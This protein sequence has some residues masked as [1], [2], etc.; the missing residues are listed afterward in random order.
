MKNK[1]VIITGASS[2]IG[3][4]TALAFHEKGAYLS[5]AARSISKLN[6]LAQAI[7][8]DGGKAIAIQTDVTSEKD[9]QE[10]VQKTVDTFGRVDILVNN[11][12]I[13]MR[14]LFDDV[15]IHVMKTLMEV[16]FWG[17]VYCTKFA[18]PYIQRSKGV[19]VGVSSIAGFHGLPGRCGYSA[20]KFALHGFLETVRIEN[21]H[22]G[23]HVLVFA[24]G[25][26]CTKIRES[27]LLANGKPQGKS[28]RNEMKMMSAEQ[29]AKELLRAIARKK[30][31]KLLTVEGKLMVFF[32]RILPEAVD[33]AAYRKMAREPGS[34]FK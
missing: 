30:R 6:M 14:A 10:L 16:N 3:H 15:E 32:Q 29:A 11:A 21:I 31:N 17:A 24:P 20:S 8:N 27:A 18:L 9:C 25:F 5:L 28:P 7:Q 12:G 13:S 26:T 4:A 33:K 34:P 2:G 1:V 19:I 23:V 22:K